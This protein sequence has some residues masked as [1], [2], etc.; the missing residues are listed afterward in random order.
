M[1]SLFF[2]R[3]N[4]IVFLVVFYAVTVVFSTLCPSQGGQNLHHQKQRVHHSLSCLLACSSLMARDA[5][6]P[7]LPSGHFLFGILLLLAA[8]HFYKIHTENFRSRAP[9]LAA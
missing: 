2:K 4:A 7:Q 6:A 3:A 9:P 1:R 8:F 5:S